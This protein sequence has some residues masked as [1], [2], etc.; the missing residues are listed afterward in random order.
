MP[1]TSEL[2]GEH[3]GPG[4][5]GPGLVGHLGQGDVQRADHAA[6]GLGDG[7]HVRL[8][9]DGDAVADLLGQRDVDA[10]HQPD[11]GVG[12]RPDGVAG[13]E[14]D[15]RVLP[16]GEPRGRLHPRGAAVL[17]GHRDALDV[18]GV[19]GVERGDEQAVLA[20][21]GAHRGGAHAAA[22]RVDGLRELLRAAPDRGDGAGLAA[23]RGDGDLLGAELVRG[24]G[25]GGPAGPGGQLV[26]GEAD[27]AGAGGGPGDDRDGRVAGGRDGLGPRLGLGRTPPPRWPGRPGGC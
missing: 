1:R 5:V 13:A 2:P 7:G 25:L 22:G 8:A 10:G 16:G 6:G 11:E 18:V 12:G 3:P 9:G 15:L 4:G 17:V 26:D 23:G 14:V 27:G 24:E 20:V 19:A 21:A